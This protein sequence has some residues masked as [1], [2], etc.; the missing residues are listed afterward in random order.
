M[1]R[2]KEFPAPLKEKFISLIAMGILCTLV[3]ICSSIIFKDMT[4]LILSILV[5]VLCLV[6]AGMFYVTVSNKEYETVTGI[7]V[8]VTHIIVH[9]QKKVKITD[10]DGN[11]GCLILG[12]HSKIEVGKSYTFYFK[13]TKRISLGNEYF[14]S[15]LS[16]DCFLGYE[17]LENNDI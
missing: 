1:L 15:V 16:S 8:S 2:F 4:M 7:C 11:E 6:K 5:L 10:S 3:G 17:E 13:S 9:K 12:K 14:D